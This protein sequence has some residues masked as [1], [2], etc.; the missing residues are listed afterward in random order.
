MWRKPADD[1]VVQAAEERLKAALSDF[2]TEVY[3][4]RPLDILGYSMQVKVL[5]DEARHI[6]A[7]SYGGS[8]AEEDVLGVLDYHATLMR[9]KVNAEL[10]ELIYGDDEDDDQ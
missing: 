6:T 1:E 3:G 4:R 2:L 10:D 9:H 5:N 8:F 7:T